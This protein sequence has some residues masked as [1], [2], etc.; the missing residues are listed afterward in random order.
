MATLDQIADGVVVVDREGHFLLFNPAAERILRLGAVNSGP[1][2]WSA[3]YGLYLPDRVTPF[4]P[5]QLPLYRAMQGETAETTDIYM[6]HESSPEGTWLSVR[7]TPLRTASGEVE[8][9]IAVFRDVSDRKQ[10]EAELVESKELA[11]AAA[12]DKSR[13]LAAMSHDIR[14]PLNTII[15]MLEVVLASDLEG[16]QREYL[17]VVRESSESLLSLIDD[18]LDYSRI[19]AGRFELHR[20]PFALREVLGDFLKSLGFLAQTKG[21]ELACRIDPAAP[22][23]LIGDPNRLRQLLGNLVTNAIKYT[24]EGEV[25]LGVECVMREGAQTELRFTVRDT[26]VGIGPEHQARIFAPYNRGD[27]R[28][29]RGSHGSGLGLAIAA[30]IVDLMHGELTL[31]SAPGA[32]S[33]FAFTV[34]FP[35]QEAW[36]SPRLAGW[37][38]M[39]GRHLLLV[40]DQGSCR[41]I[42]KELLE[43]WG[44]RVSVAA[45][46]EEALRALEATPPDTILI[47]AE[48]PGRDGF[49]LAEQLVETRPDLPRTM[50][51]SSALRLDDL[52][53]CEDLGVCTCVRKPIKHS[54]L[55]EAL[56]LGVDK[57]RQARRELSR[58]R[59]L[60]SSR[61]RRILLAEDNLVNRRLAGAILS[62]WGHEVLFA[63]NGKEAIALAESESPDL[64]L[65]DVEMPEMDGLEAS[66]GIREWES[67]TNR[68]PTPIFA[69]TAHVM[70]ADRERC[71]EAGMDEVVVKPFD[72]EELFARIESLP[73]RRDEPPRTARHVPE[74]RS[75]LPTRGGPPPS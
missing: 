67:E 55:Q 63:D 22:D 13:F 21:L 71:R 64:I 74:R 11:E 16:A 30:K 51:L 9:G 33:T 19:E 23:G 37:D 27:P 7:A 75:A 39:E 42:L 26:G 48:M 70:E 34:S 60:V 59:G 4:P 61:P 10:V 38:S 41:G 35:L 69:L 1:T 44:L 56:L 36:E 31:D 2:T 18:L 14:S 65:M 72:I 53:R 29:A 45:G 66:R 32:G 50:M 73:P 47:D 25:V 62:G 54:E 46:A 6:R 28:V 58:G 8:G 40:D 52:T 43:S 3:H 17:R 68:A 20:T 49:W 15:G 57:E 24:E 12:V 5:D